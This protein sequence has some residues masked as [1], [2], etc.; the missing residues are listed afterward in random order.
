MKVTNKCLSLFMSND[1]I[2]GIVVIGCIGAFILRLSYSL[3]YFKLSIFNFN[4]CS[5]YR[6]NERKKYD[7]IL[8]YFDQN[9]LN[10][11]VYSM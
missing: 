11:L 8:Q 6:P 4:T 1:Y 9:A 5:Q 2:K 7:V 3:F 10:R